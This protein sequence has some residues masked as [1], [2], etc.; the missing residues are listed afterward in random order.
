M[1]FPVEAMADLPDD[2]KAA[3]LAQLEHMQVRDSL[4][5]YNSLVER[6]FKDCVDEF[7]SKNLSKDEEKCVSK[8][9]EKFMNVSARTGLRF[10]EFFTE[11]EK[12][13]AEAAKAA[14][15]RR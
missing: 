6:C 7:R 8:C 9:C 3:F 10:Q 5:L 2:H 11:M 15:K 12:Q 13:A 4:K 1:N 14:S